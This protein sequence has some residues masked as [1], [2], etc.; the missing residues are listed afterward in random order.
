MWNRLGLGLH[1]IFHPIYFFFVS[2]GGHDGIAGP[3]ILYS[4]M[5]T[6]MLPNLGKQG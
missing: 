3:Q 2:H 4:L 1:L 6:W 5:A